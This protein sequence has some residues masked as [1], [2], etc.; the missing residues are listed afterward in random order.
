MEKSWNRHGSISVQKVYGSL[1]FDWRALSEEAPPPPTVVSDLQS[2]TAMPK[3]LCIKS[4]QGKKK[5]RSNLTQLISTPTS[6]LLAIPFA[7]FLLGPPK[8]SRN[9]K[10]GPSHASP[11]HPATI[12][13]WLFH[14]FPAGPKT[15]GV[16]FAAWDVRIKM[17]TL[18]WWFET[19]KIEIFCLMKLP[20]PKKG[21]VN[22]LNIFMILKSATSHSGKNSTVYSL[23]NS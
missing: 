16:F 12:F 23:D 4:S 9:Q 10:S 18:W 5:T 19:S 3:N 17:V 2:T 1:S 13:L 15:T 7:T 21:H 6:P 20:H 8:N 14:W 22:V 11:C